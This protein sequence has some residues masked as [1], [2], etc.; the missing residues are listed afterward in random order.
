MRVIRGTAQDSPARASPAT[1]AQLRIGV[2]QEAWHADAEE[3]ERRLGD[4][5]RL[6]AAEGARL[7]CTQELTLSP[8]FA[9]TPDGDGSS[10]EEIP[11]GRTSRWAVQL[12]R[13]T[14]AYVHSS[15]FEKAPDGGMGY[16]TAIVAS[17]DGEIVARTRKVHIPGGAGYHE[18]QYFRPGAPGPEAFDVVALEGAH[19]GFPTCWDQW[20]P[21]LARIYS[22]RGA[23]VIVYPSAI[24]TEPEHP[25]F[26]TEPQWESVITANG[27]MNGTFMVVINRI[28]TEGALTFY[29]SSFVSDPYGRKLVQAPRDEPAVLIADLDLDQRRDWLDLFPLLRARRPELYGDLVQCP[30]NDKRG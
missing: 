5:V 9:S 2:V 18:N 3:H 29:G 1:R 17:P 25:D 22:I 19:F 26:D 28:G 21:E 20:F 7:V 16:D 14:G 23:E 6:A 8:Y 27:V 10:A 13:E 30:E 15:L 12:A 24:G 4:A 11:D